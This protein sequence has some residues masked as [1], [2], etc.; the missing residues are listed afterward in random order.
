MQKKILLSAYTCCPNAG[1]E[2]GNGWCWLTGYLNNGYEVHCVTSSKYRSEIEEW[3]TQK[4]PDRLFLYY[5]DNRLTLSALKLPAGLYLHYYC[6]LF[7]ARKIVK[8]LVEKMDFSH[9]HHVT[10]SSIKYG[11]PLYDLPCKIVLGPLGE[12][13]MPHLSLRKY[14]GSAFYTAYAKNKVSNILEAVNP[15]VKRSVRSA[16]LILTATDHVRSKIK[17]YT[18]NSR[19]ESMFFMLNDQ[20]EQ[21]F[22]QKQI[23]GRINILW[24]GRMFPKKGLNLAIDAISEL[25]GDF[26][27]HFLVAGDGP[28]MKKVKQQVQDH[29]LGE[30]VTFLSKVPHDELAPLFQC[31]HILLFPS[32]MDSCPMQIFEAMAFG[33]PVVT[34]DH[35]GMSLQVSEKTGKKITVADHINYPK[36]LSQAI[37]E[38]CAND[39]TYQRY[40]QHAYQ[41][42]QQQVSRKSIPYFLSTVNG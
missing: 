13:Q 25:P 29:D 20:F 17:K 1:S 40:S 32:F 42:G 4:K 38:I 26:D 8:E 27:F 5:T 11:T 24:I 7:R 2:P 33:L 35:Q 10:Y 9:S 23:N 15:L 18:S 41:F 21:P 22:R 3:L 30:K 36:E 12:T 19:T 39:E 6:W 31:S 28:E 14:L 16:D 34:L 37:L